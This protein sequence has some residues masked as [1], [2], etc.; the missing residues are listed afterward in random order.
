MTDIKSNE[1]VYF[2]WLHL[3]AVRYNE[4]Y[5]QRLTEPE[6]QADSDYAHY[7]TMRIRYEIL[8]DEKGEG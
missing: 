1:Q 4:L 2:E 3:E 7:K 6:I 8:V 5:D